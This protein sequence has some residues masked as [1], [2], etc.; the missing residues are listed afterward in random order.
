MTEKEKLTERDYQEPI[1]DRKFS[2]ADFGF[3]FV[4]K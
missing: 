3:I 1:R 4:V 2:I